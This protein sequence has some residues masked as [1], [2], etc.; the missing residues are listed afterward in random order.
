[1]GSVYLADQVQ[2]VRRQVALKLIKP[3]MD[4]RTV[5]ARF[6]SE[7]QALAVMDH[8]H[9]AKV[10]DAGTTDHGRPFF[11]MEL[12]Q[13]IPLTDY[14]DQHRLGL[15]ERLALFRQICSAVQ[16]AHQKGIIHRDLKPTNILV[17]EQDGNP[18][19]KIIDFGL[20]KATD[21]H[22]LGD[23]TAATASDNLAGTPLY[24]APEQA[25]FH[26][27][28]IDTRADIYALGVILYELLTGSTPI[29]RDTI[30]RAALDEMLRV[31]REDEPPTPSSRIGKS[32]ELPNIASARQTDPIRLGRFVRGDL[33]WVV[34]KALSKERSRRYDSA[35]G[36][37][38]DIE[39]FL[40]HEPVSAGPPSTW[41]RT[42]KF[43]RRHRS[44][45]VAASL[46]FLTL[47]GGVMGTT[48][49]LI[50]ANHQRRNAEVAAKEQW[51]ARGQE[52]AQRVHAEEQRQLAQAHLAT[53]D[54]RLTQVEKLNEMLGSIFRDLD[55]RNMEKDR[56]PLAVLLGER[57][58]RVSAEIE[59]DAIGDPV[60]VARMQRILGES[61]L[62]LGHSGKAIALFTKARTTFDA[63]LGA[64]HPDALR[65]LDGIANASLEDGQRPLALSLFEQCLAA[66]K[67]KLGDDH[68]DTLASLH[69][70]ANTYLE[71]RRWKSA[72]PLLEQCLAA[73]E[74]K[75]GK[76]HPDTLVTL[77]R[78][79]YALGESGRW[80]EALP[81]L[82]RCHEEMK[83]RLGEDHPDTLLNLNSLAYACRVTGQW[84]RA[85]LLFKQCY[86]GRKAR[87]GDD[88]RD[89]LASLNNL[90]YVYIQVGRG[91]EGIPLMERAFARRWAKL[92][93][94]HPDTVQSSVDLGVVHAQTG[95]RKS[96][97]PLLKKL[98]EGD[99]ARLGPDHP[100]TLWARELLAKTDREDGTLDRAVTLLENSYATTKA[101]QGA[102]Y[103]DTF[104]ILGK[105]AMA[106]RTAGKM[107][108]AVS[109]Y[110]EMLAAM[111]EHLGP[112][113]PT[114]LDAIRT[115]A[116]CRRDSGRLDLALPLYAQAYKLRKAR[117]GPDHPDTLMS[118]S[119]LGVA[120]RDAGHLDK[121]IPLLEAAY[122]S[123][124][125]KL[126]P[127]HASTLD[128]MNNLVTAYRITHSPDKAAPLLE[129]SL[130]RLKAKSGPD[131]P[132]TLRQMLDLAACY[133]GANKFKDE[134]KTLR[135]FAKIKGRKEGIDSPAYAQSLLHV[136]YCLIRQEKWGDAEP[137]LRT[138]L[139]IRE[140]KLSDQWVTFNTK[141]LL[142]EALHGQGRDA[143]AVLFLKDGYEGM[144]QRASK[145][146]KDRKFHLTDALDR[147]IKFSHDTGKPDEAQ[148]WRDEKAKLA[149]E[150]ATPKAAKP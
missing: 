81:Y 37:A 135:D 64:D 26:A 104:D 18:V 136:G 67:A 32:E 28:D 35:V 94:N 116:E 36:L 106:C 144:K 147:L 7:R 63:R 150:V 88:H 138:V 80:P 98:V 66:R 68:P 62:G 39:R 76:A 1:M 125:A 111:S 14:C 23:H 89:T 86:E 118:L 73:R 61:L 70:L 10:L 50:E 142:G 4:T 46:V 54:K 107:D 113:H 91:D 42:R 13:G 143:E 137:I 108:R 140:A 25:M 44:Q 119:N 27:I 9:I 55:P 117:Q 60:A 43:A 8:P 17:E 124:K 133:Q 31:I 148:A 48:W 24:M 45:V 127:D 22:H 2:P 120:H 75:L 29:R 103:R 15:P 114:T 101:K 102:D 52:A 3:G 134:E 93:P 49:G 74:A 34:M 79:A 19:P 56:K 83:A 110:E 21:G 149:A 71:M 90:G 40:N 145:I 109:L 141:S 78:L 123:G 65:C 20:A 87:L 41:Y 95:R 33:D 38:N 115:F 100:D 85:L 84:D 16:H 58:E 57:L 77:G 112:D 99:M 72:T 59:G 82:E 97:L 12:V 5:L 132:D 129:Q 126:G 130:E 69:N 131:H 51:R 146:S 11:V 105:L 53:S 30:R 122:A 121:A 96:F 128:A 6:E 92:G 139:S 47:V